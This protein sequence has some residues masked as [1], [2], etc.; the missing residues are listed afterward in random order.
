MNTA[1]ATFSVNQYRSLLQEHFGFPDLRD[2]QEQVLHELADHDV[3]A[4]MPTG[5]GKSMCYILPAL[6]TGRTLV[7]SP[8]IA[9][10]Q[11]QL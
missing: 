1:R 3:V 6:A 5:S 11:D 4:V 2:G 10:M 8:L 9:L 7:V